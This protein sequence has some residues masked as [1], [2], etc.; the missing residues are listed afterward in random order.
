MCEWKAK[1]CSTIR[2]SIFLY[3]PTNL[4]AAVGSKPF[5]RSSGREKIPM[6]TRPGTLTPKTVLL[7]LL[8]SVHSMVCAVL[9]W[10]ESVLHFIR[11]SWWNVGTL[12]LTQPRHALAAV[13][14]R[15]LLDEPFCALFFLPYLSLLMALPVW[16][17][18]AKSSKSET[19]LPARGDESSPFPGGWA[20]WQSGNSF[21]SVI[22][23]RGNCGDHSYSRI[24]HDTILF[25]G[26][27]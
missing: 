5:V 14:R 1:K 10:T 18:T 25:F 17:P 19:L 4:L 6:E 3:I 24:A 27:T 13:S 21:L 9:C 26:N 7:L 20:Q 11:S 12:G 8:D 16:I 22:T 15:L 23:T 2:T